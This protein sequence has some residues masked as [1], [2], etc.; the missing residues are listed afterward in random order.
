MRLPTQPLLSVL[1]IILGLS[2][3]FA[4]ARDNVLKAIP[5]DTIAFAVV[6]NLADASRAIGEVAKLV[7]A[8]APDLLNMAKGMTGLQK[9]LD[10]KG[11]LVLV[12]S[13]IETS[14]PKGVMLVPVANFDDF[15]AALN[16]KEPASGAVEVQ[17][18]GQPAFV[19]R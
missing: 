15:F 18:A 10:E 9:G 13:S 14:P 19:G 17:L 1:C 6:H 8:P 3:T 11:D 16:V 12:L 5:D 7:H 4:Q 2:T